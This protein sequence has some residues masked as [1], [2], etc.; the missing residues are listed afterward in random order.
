NRVKLNIKLNE[1]TSRKPKT[2]FK[3]EKTNNISIQFYINASWHLCKTT[4]CDGKFQNYSRFLSV[5][6]SDFNSFTLKNTLKQYREPSKTDCFHKEKRG[7]LGREQ[8][9]IHCFYTKN[10]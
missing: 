7:V 4:R 10:S 6:A 8:S 2:S 9:G 3:R 1:Q 5:S